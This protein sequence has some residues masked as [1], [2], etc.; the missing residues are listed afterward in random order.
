[1][2]PMNAFFLPAARIFP[3][4]PSVI[5]G[6]F[7]KNGKRFSGNIIEI[8]INKKAPGKR[9]TLSLKI[10]KVYLANSDEEKQ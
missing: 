3:E 8:T 9:L 1:M 10:V 4:K 6:V 2:K 5:F 7:H